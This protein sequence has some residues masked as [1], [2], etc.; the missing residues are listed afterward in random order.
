MDQLLIHVKSE[1]KQILKKRASDEGVTLKELVTRALDLYLGAG[2]GE[3]I[4]QPSFKNHC[5]KCKND[6]ESLKENPNVCPSCK[7]YSWKEKVKPEYDHE[8]SACG[9][10]WTNKIPSPVI[11]PCCKSRAWNPDSPAYQA[12][13]FS[14]MYTEWAGDKFAATQILAPHMG[15]SFGWLSRCVLG[16]EAVTPEMFKIMEKVYKGEIKIEEIE[17]KGESTSAADNPCQT[18]DFGPDLV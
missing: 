15:V 3:N 12:E 16:R 9:H 14:T 11:C 2:P 13:R 1:T 17:P 6:W 10:L 4:L 18:Y 8:C 5:E 7:S